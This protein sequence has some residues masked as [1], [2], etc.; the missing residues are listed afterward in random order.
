MGY[1]EIFRESNEE[2]AERYELV[3]ERIAEIR[4]E[5]TVSEKYQDYFQKAAEFICLAHKVLEQEETGVLENRTL[6]AC[7]ETNQQ[8]YQDILPSGYEKS[9]ANPAV[10]IQLLGEEFG[11]LLCFL[12]SELR[13]MI[14]YA[15]EGRKMHFT[16]LC[17]L[18]MEIYNCFEAD[19]EPDKKEVKN[20]IYWFFHDYSEIFAEDKVRDM[21][22]PEYDFFAKIIMESDLSDMRYLYRYGEYI[23][24]SEIAVAKFLNQLS[25]EEIQSMAD[26]MTEGFRIGFETTGKDL[27]KKETVCMEYPIGFERVVRAAIF[28]FE[29]LGL[30]VTVYRDPVSS[31]GRTNGGKR[32]CYV[33]SVNKQYEFDHKADRSLYLDKAY[34]ERRLEAMKAAF[35]KYKKQANHHAGPAVMEIFGEI[36]F[37]PVFKLEAPKY[38]PEQ[39]ELN[40]YQMSR[41]GQLTNTYIPGDE[42]SFTIIAYPIPT[43]G[44]K[45]EEIFRETVKINTLDY[46]TYRNMQQKIIDVLDTAD[47]VHIT[48]KGAN[49]TDLWVK[50]HPLTNPKK[51]TAFENCVADVNIPV[52]E[53]FTSPVL[54]GTEGKLHVTQVYL[55]ELKYLNLEIDFVD[56]KIAAYTCSNF[57]TEEENQRFLYENLLHHHDTLPMGEFAIGTNTT[58]YRMARDYDIADKL[59]ILIAEKTGPHFA[60]GDTCYSHAEDT[61]VYNPDG[62][63]IVARDNEISIL[64]KEDMEKAYFNCHTDITIPYDELDTIVAVEKDGTTRDIIRDGKFVVSGTEELNIPLT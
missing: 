6:K 53:V 57:A 4:T 34:V 27:S 42:R 46:M 9:Y 56:G 28:N 13:A 49:K 25:E 58:A 14:S 43:I 32:G 2:V 35:E 16:I 59:P 55:N 61:K 40:V 11:S 12:Y 44:E 62:K 41:L 26:T 24:E 30:K 7:E 48:G 60:V 33:K 1:K 63:E 64:R 39:N 52:G 50:I 20:I 29:K 23:S 31:F 36:P 47:R 51:E 18:F 5:N 38:S 15:F 3:I 22:D 19:N 45:F 8:L 37:E 10:A 17:E 21:V 54:S